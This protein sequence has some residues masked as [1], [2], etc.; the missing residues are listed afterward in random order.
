MARFS[1]E[2]GGTC[3][4]RAKEAA[5]RAEGALG[6]RFVDTRAPAPAPGPAG[7]GPAPALTVFCPFSFG[8]PAPAPLGRASP[9][10]RPETTVTLPPTVS[11]GRCMRISLP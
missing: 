11:H 7:P 1:P 8:P 10:L 5:G 2:G 3:W 9:A 6:P 4:I